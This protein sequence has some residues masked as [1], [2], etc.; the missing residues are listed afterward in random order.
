MSLWHIPVFA[1]NRLYW[2][3]GIWSGEQLSCQNPAKRSPPSPRAF[4]HTPQ[5]S[6]RSRSSCC[7]GT[8]PP[9]A[10]D[11]PMKEVSVE[12]SRACPKGHNL[13]L[14]SLG[15]VDLQECFGHVWG[16]FD[17]YNNLGV[18]P[19]LTSGNWALIQCLKG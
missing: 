15:S 14:R 12:L 18:R 10:S 16:I 19:Q 8:M 4:C 5:C 17:C 1:N 7:I 2:V 11:W 3:R 13:W 6:H 9:R